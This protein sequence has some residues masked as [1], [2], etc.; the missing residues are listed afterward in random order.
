MQH[1]TNYSV[2]LTG[3]PSLPLPPPTI[4]VQPNT[5]YG[6][7]SSLSPI[8]ANSNPAYGQVT[9][10]SGTYQQGNTDQYESILDYQTRL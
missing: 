8:T 7:I 4:S 5:S 9:I 3:A 6:Q 10:D 2:H 1:L